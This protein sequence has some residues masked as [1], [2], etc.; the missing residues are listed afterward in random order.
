MNPKKK[1]LFFLLV[2][3]SLPLLG[4]TPGIDGTARGGGGAVHGCSGGVASSESGA[5]G[6]DTGVGGV[7]ASRTYNFNRGE[8]GATY[9]MS[10]SLNKTYKIKTQLGYFLSEGT[11]LSDSYQTF[12]P[13][14]R[15]ILNQPP[16]LTVEPSENPSGPK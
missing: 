8:I 3:F 1:I 4:F 12:H 10:S 5:E 15:D 9:N 2:V 6:E 11:T 7:A 14:S 16:A 13:M